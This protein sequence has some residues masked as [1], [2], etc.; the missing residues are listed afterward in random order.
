[1][2]ADGLL[3]PPR[4]QRSRDSLRRIVE[5]GR[6]LLRERDFDSVTVD[7]IVQRAGSSKGAFYHRFADKEGL[8]LHLL[9]LEHD[10]AVVAWSELLAPERWHDRPLESALDA[11]LDRLLEIYRGQPSLMRSYAGKIFA[12]END[13]RDHS[14]RLTSHVLGLLRVI[15]GEKT[16]DMRHPDPEV[17]TAFLLTT[18]ITLLPPLFLYPDSGLM[19][20]PLD[21]D[22]LEREV[23]CLI[24]SYV[25]VTADGTS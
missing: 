10:E 21:T 6:D 20:E 14:T 11:F 22:T 5:A 16:S 1:M 17:A 4:Q 25:G 12:G 18:L 19:P 23:R 2:G 7:D 9:K 13:V 24:R 3:H 8:L 15:V